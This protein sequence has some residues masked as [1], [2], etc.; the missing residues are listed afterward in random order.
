MHLMRD[1]PYF[2]PCTKNVL[3][4]YVD[5]IF[6][7]YPLLLYPY[8]NIFI[9]RVFPFYLTVREENPGYSGPGLQVSKLL[10]LQNMLIAFSSFINPSII[11]IPTVLVFPA[12]TFP[13]IP[14]RFLL[15]KQSLIPSNPS[16]PLLLA[17]ALF[18]AVLA[19][20]A[21]PAF[22]GFP[23]SIRISRIH[24]IP[25]FSSFLAFVSLLAFHQ[26]C[27]SNI[28]CSPSTSTIRSKLCISNIPSIRILALRPLQ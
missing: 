3:R 28:Q 27:I 22:H 20:P 10:T 15:F 24:N 9:K 2:A 18:L 19:Y 8:S 4:R 5:S 11:S 26:S 25:S 6:Q 21:I 7:S 23:S 1:F 13:S 12:R 14:N 17:F 16:V